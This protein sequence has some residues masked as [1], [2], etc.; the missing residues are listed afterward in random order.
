MMQCSCLPEL[1]FLTTFHK[2]GGRGETL[3]TT[4]CPKTVVV[5]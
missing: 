2:N 4:T 3:G 1:V 5:G